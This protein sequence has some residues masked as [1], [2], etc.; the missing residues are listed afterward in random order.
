MT[1][2]STTRPSTQRPAHLNDPRSALIHW[3]EPTEPEPD[4]GEQPTKS[5]RGYYNRPEWIAEIRQRIADMEAQQLEYIEAGLP[6][7]AANLQ[8]QIDMYAP[9]VTNARDQSHVIRGL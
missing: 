5:H 9:I 1:T 3:K 8:P 2:D 4:T 7:M 6:H